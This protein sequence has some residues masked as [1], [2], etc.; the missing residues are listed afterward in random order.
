MG[1]QRAD[2]ALWRG[3]ALIALLLLL[4]P[5][6]VP[7]PIPEAFRTAQ[8]ATIRQDYEA[9]AHALESA[10]E[11]LPYDG[12]VA[13]RA[14]LAHISARQFDSAIRRLLISAALDGW[15]PAKRI[16][17]GD[18]YLGQGNRIE[19]LAQWELVLK[20]APD[21]DGLLV[22]LANTYEA[23]GRY[24]EA[25][26]ALTRL[27]ELRP[28][29]AV[30]HYRLALLT[31]AT[32]P[33]DALARLTLAGTL[34][35]ELA[36]STQA[37]TQAIEEGQRSGDEAYLFGR[38]GFAFVQL[39]EWGL[40]ELAL[41]RAVAL[42]PDYADGHAYL[43]LAQDMQAQDGLAELE[44][45]QRLA[46]ESPL[47]QYFLGLHWKRAGDASRALPHLQQ[48]Q[49]LDPENPA[50]AAELGG[51]YASLNDLA[52]AEVWFT[53]AVRVAPQSPEFWLLLARFY[54]DYEYH[55]VELG[56]PAA[57]MAAGLN[58][59]SA[60]AADALG[61]A[62]VLTG[63]SVNGEKTLERALALDPNLPSVYYHLGI[64]YASQGKN[65]EAEAVFNH[66][67]ALDPDGPY[68]GLALKALAQITAP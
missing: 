63:D 62:L 2:G 49:K 35:S 25:V 23:L 28:A 67:L 33:A 61:Y 15:T 58:P 18:A 36:A 55:V 32:A 47:I 5:Q 38:V 31:A 65:A 4:A 10:A 68:G 3:L 53:E 24:P 39:K 17:L 43:G 45:A 19:A 54:T 14:G 37:L 50:L 13:Y 16:A 66:A 21:D 56:L 52:Q 46:P 42:N 57:R 29:D 9:A 44:A 48:A 7:L 20:D 30:V 51:A 59:A 64:L 8:A 27:A 1:A 41:A 6:P 11:R 40:A 22:R 34:S 60:L 26:S 12:Y